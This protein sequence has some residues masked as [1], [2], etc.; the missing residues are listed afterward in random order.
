MGLYFDPVPLLVDA[1]E[2][3]RGQWTD[4]KWLNVPGPFYGAVT[5]NCGTGRI[6]APD[7]V[8]YEGEYFSEYVYRQPRTAEELQQL[9]D[10]ADADPWAGYGC[11]GDEHWTLAAVREWWRDR[12][13]V[14]EYLVDRRGEWEADDEKSGQGTAAAALDYASYLDGELASHLRIYL[15]WLDERRSPTPTD[16]LPEL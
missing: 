12:G 7:L 16:R 15:Y 4:R 2:S 11:D 14:R 1:H 8:L 3:F 5:D 10:A 6:H 13:R 9:V